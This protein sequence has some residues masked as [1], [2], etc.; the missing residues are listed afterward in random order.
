MLSITDISVRIAGRLLIDQSS[1]QIVPGA[2]VGFVGRNGVGK[3]TLFHAI[4]GDLP[5]G[6][7]S[8]TIPPRWRIGSLAQEAP[9]GPESLINDVLQADLARDALLRA[10]AYSHDSH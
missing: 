5:T 2:R 9:D 8:I 4:R 1:V 3:S 10:A 6:S 7:G